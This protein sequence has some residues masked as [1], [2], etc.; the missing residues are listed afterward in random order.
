M[1]KSDKEFLMTQEIIIGVA[2]ALI[3]AVLVAVH[4]YLHKLL[5]FKMDESAIV[6]FFVHQNEDYVFRSTAS[7]A[8]A[9]D[10]STERVTAVC[11][12][13][14]KIKRNAKEKESWCLKK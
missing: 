11:S 10:I 13:S 7:I 2:I 14:K 12:K 3:V 1:Y 5:I 9:T 6:N 8:S 4:G